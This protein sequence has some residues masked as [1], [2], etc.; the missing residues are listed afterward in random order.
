LR[1]PSPVTARRGW[2]IDK[3]NRFDKIDATVAM[4]MAI[5]RLEDRPAPTRL[6]GW[7]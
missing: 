1:P 7:L 3:A 5:D 6:V 2:R 4:C